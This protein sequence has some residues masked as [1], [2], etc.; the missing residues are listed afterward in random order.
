MRA[1][2]KDMESSMKAS[3][4]NRFVA[5]ITA[6]LLTF[7][8]QAGSAQD[9]YGGV[10][11]SLGY[12]DVTDNGFPEG[13]SGG[14]TGSAFAGRTFGNGFFAEGD[15]RLQLYDTQDFSNSSLDD[16]QLVALRFGRDW[17][18][19]TGEAILGYTMAHTFEGTTGRGFFA[20]AGT[21][22]LS[23]GMT[24]T[25]LLGYLDGTD[26]T[27]DDGLDGYSEMVHV[28]LGANYQINDRFGLW[29]NATY[30]EGIMDDDTPRDELGRV[31]EVALGLDYTFANPALK[32][33]LGVSYADHYQGGEDDSAYEKWVNLGVVWTFGD[34][35][36]RGSR[37]RPVLP[38]YENWL[39]T[40]ASI[41]E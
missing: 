13:H 5:I 2:R 30:G 20:I 32:G 37:T 11:L 27:D 41:L 31:Q 35:G 6:A 36:K 18:T 10:D 4:K 22:E 3:P 12:T 33:Y 7:S 9:I 25:G 21:H 15:L 26:G 29:G 34:T 1:N 23:P 14:I 16:S 19:T 39:A 38:Q 24:V 17:G 8:G 40:S 28:S